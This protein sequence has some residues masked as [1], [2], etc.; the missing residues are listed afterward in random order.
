MSYTVEYNP[1]LRKSYPMKSKKNGK[2][3]LKPVVAALG[4][5]VSLYVLNTLGVLRLLLPG[6]PAVTTGAFSSMVEDVRDGQRVSDAIFSFF[7]Y[8]IKGGQ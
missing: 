8:V 5:I 7:Q 2:I 4:I 3:P 1:E 6:D